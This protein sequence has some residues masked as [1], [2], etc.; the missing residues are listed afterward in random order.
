MRDVLCWVNF[1]AHLSCL[2]TCWLNWTPFGWEITAVW[3]A[4]CVL[5]RFFI[6]IRGFI[7][8][9][10]SAALSVWFFSSF[11]LLLPSSNWFCCLRLFHAKLFYHW[12][13]YT[14][15][16]L[17]YSISQIP[18][19]SPNKIYFRPFLP[20]ISLWTFFK[21][22]GKNKPQICEILQF[23]ILWEQSLQKWYLKANR[24]K[25]SSLN[26]KLILF[27]WFL[28]IQFD[29]IFIIW[30]KWTLN[31]LRPF[32]R[33]SI[34]TSGEWPKPSDMS[35]S[36]FNSPFN[37]YSPNPD[38][39]SMTLKSLKMPSPIP[40]WICLIWWVGTNVFRVFMP[41]SG[42]CATWLAARTFWGKI[43]RREL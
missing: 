11:R 10:C 31:N 26:L 8:F 38:K 5:I 7:G 17:F 12:D 37:K 3:C 18:M 13:S 39:N 43:L 19:L 33:S 27:W 29:F 32:S 20:T 35:S 14:T 21:P 24:I 22:Y 34:I 9:N 2:M 40:T 36:I 15:Y 25:L 28:Y 6:F 41:L 42:I 1:F 30:R 23:V 16:N 4:V